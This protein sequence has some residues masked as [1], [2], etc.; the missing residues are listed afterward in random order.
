MLIATISP[1]TK[2]CRYCYPFSLPLFT[3]FQFEMFQPTATRT[4]CPIWVQPHSTKNARNML[5]KNNIIFSCN[6]LGEDKFFG[7]HL[8]VSSNFHFKTFGIQMYE[9]I[10]FV[11]FI[12]IPF[13]KFLKTIA[14]KKLHIIHILLTNYQLS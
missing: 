6:M 10:I 14:L 11:S 12:R 13:K 7:I 9:K 3:H 5:E 1:K 2:L 8:Y 4:I